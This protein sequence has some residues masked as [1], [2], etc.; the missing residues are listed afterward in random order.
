MISDQVSLVMDTLVWAN[1]ME[2]TYDGITG[3]KVDSLYKVADGTINIT[4]LKYY[5]RYPMKFDLMSFVTPYGINLD[6]GQ[7]GKTWTFDVTDFG[8]ILKGWKRITVEDGGQWME[9]MDIQFA[10]IVGTPSREVLDIRQIWRPAN[11][12]NADILADKAFEPRQFKMNGNGSYFKIRTL[13]TGHGQEG[14]FI[15]RSHSLNINEGN[16]EFSWQVWKG[17]A[18]NPVYPQGGTWIY[19]RAGWCP[20]AP[21]NLQES[22]ITALVTPGQSH[23]I[24][25]T[26]A[27]ATGSSN[28]TVSNQM[29]TYGN[30]NFSLDAALIDITAP[31]NKVEYYRSNMICT[32][33]TI[34]IQNNGTTPLTQVLIKYW[35]NNS[36]QP[37]TYT[38]TGNLSYLQK[39]NVSLPSDAQLWSALL[40]SNN[41][42]HAQI[43]QCNGVSD[44]YLINNKFHSSFS[45]PDVLPSPFIIMLYTNNAPTETS[46]KLLNEG[47][48]V[49]FEKNNLA[50]KKIYRDTFTLGVG[51]YQLIVEDSDEDGLSFFANSDGAG[52][53]NVRRI[54]GSVIKSFDPDFGK[55]I[56]YNFTVDY[57]LSFDDL[58]GQKQT[59]VFPNPSQGVFTLS[60]ADDAQQLIVTD[61]MGKLIMTQEISSQNLSEFKLDLTNQPNGLY[62][63][64]IK[65]AQRD[66]LIKMMI[67]K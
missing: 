54:N 31:S 11:K 12:T 2:Y 14:E 35:L 17:C 8:P 39:T 48:Q 40:P 16:P 36:T 3:L 6:L 61:A 24:D 55:R 1:G 4:T 49:L 63:L 29:V 32:Q 22:D 59:T 50:A 43:E 52:Y 10:F 51:C 46:Y 20:G 21:T 56:V 18:E 34:V 44:S 30:A 38:W 33:P 26:M 28:Y 47:G 60:L 23:W 41:V 9:D 53:I 25:Y 67:A 58:Y 5:G 45:I 62:L 42:F 15:P 57:P 37:L 66:E 65:G 19:D 27:A 7:N 64:R 13:I